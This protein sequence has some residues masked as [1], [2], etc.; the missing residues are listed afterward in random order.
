MR[1]YLQ[2]V[3]FLLVIGVAAQSGLGQGSTRETAVKTKN[4]IVL[5][6]AAGDAAAEALQFPKAEGWQSGQKTPI[7]SPG[8]GYAIGYD[9][10]GYGA[11]TV[12]VYSHGHERIPDQLDGV[13]KQEIEG[14]AEAIRTVAGMGIYSEVKEGKT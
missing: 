3:F 9:S 5:T 7:P 2:T 8:D 4:S 14:A 1:S 11:V 10:P 13:I 12:Y 6:R